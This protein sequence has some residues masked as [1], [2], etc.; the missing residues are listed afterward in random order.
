MTETVLVQEPSGEQYWKKPKDVK[1]E[2]VV[3]HGQQKGRAEAERIV[4]EAQKKVPAEVVEHPSGLTTIKIERP[5]PSPTSP[6]TKT[7]RVYKEG[8][9]WYYEEKVKPKEKPKEIAQPVETVTEVPYSEYEKSKE[10]G[11]QIKRPERLEPIRE[12]V[13]TEIIERQR[14]KEEAQ[15]R[16]VEVWKPYEEKEYPPLGQATFKATEQ[17]GIPQMSYMLKEHPE[18]GRETFSYVTKYPEDVLPQI[19]SAPFLWSYD[20]GREMTGMAS[21]GD[22][23]GIIGTGIGVVA[24]IGVGSK[25]FR[26]K[27]PKVS[28]SIELGEVSYSQKFGFI[29]GNILTKI[30]KKKIGTEARTIF[31]IP[32]TETEPSIG[33][34]LMRTFESEI[35]MP[36]YRV[37]VSEVKSLGRHKPHVTIEVPTITKT[38]AGKGKIEMPVIQV[39]GLKLGGEP[40]LGYT[41]TPT[42]PPWGYEYW[43]KGAFKEAIPEYQKEPIM[44]EKGA[45]AKITGR[46]TKKSLLHHEM[47]HRRY[48]R[49]SESE[50]LG[51]EFAK[52]GRK[53]L[54]ERFRF[55]EKEPGKP[56]AFLDWIP[57]EKGL[58]IS[59]GV[60]KTQ[61]VTLEMFKSS[62]PETKP[63]FVKKPSPKPISSGGIF[64][65]KQF[66]EIFF[67][68]GITKSGEIIDT[69]TSLIWKKK[70]PEM[71]IY[72]EKPPSVMEKP[73]PLPEQHLEV[74]GKSLERQFTPSKVKP[75]YTVG[76]LGGMSESLLRKSIEPEYE[77][78]AYPSGREAVFP[79]KELGLEMRIFSIEET[80]LSPAQATGLLSR[81]KARQRQS[82]IQEVLPVQKEGQIQL[83]IL[84]ELT[85]QIPRQKQLTREMQIMRPTHFTM[86]M[87]FPIVPKIMVP[88]ISSALYLPSIPKGRKGRRS[89]VSDQFTLGTR[90]TP[91]VSAVMFDIFGEMPRQKV[92][93]GI[94]QRPVTR[95]KRK[96][97]SL[98]DL[99][100]NA[101]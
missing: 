19:V 87:T 12:T 59:L 6:T 100:R 5:P 31:T 1:P 7:Q 69:S 8:E 86:T 43:S 74:V 71:G 61:K 64:Y 50:V 25:L 38:I 97:I 53:E 84:G 35:K 60:A 92:F 65:G 47:L 40:V 62:P 88:P 54:F 55:V 29:K 101:R 52:T 99:L 9:E 78:V 37:G 80:R 36:Q 79:K 56:S 48:P 85:E 24:V 83:S 34:T 66:E 96:E 14:E 81:Q 16:L 17:I 28:T 32:K 39:K 3:L 42:R 13:P 95:K 90:Y 46:A 51:M 20:V 73:S 44:I 26:G 10:V 30:G 68:R 33:L 49:A 27:P 15:R 82:P 75:S 18:A 22:I 70:P 11:E 89:F 72:F 63:F 23:A 67:S 57:S 94:E 91:T 98:L 4:S 76:G 58:D 45:F 93:A 2:D 77:I 41:R 21:R